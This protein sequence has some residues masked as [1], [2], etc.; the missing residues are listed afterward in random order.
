MFVIVGNRLSDGRNCELWFGA[1]Q[2]AASKALARLTD[3][4]R[5]YYVNFSIVERAP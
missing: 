4:L 2:K 3:K 5:G 1:N